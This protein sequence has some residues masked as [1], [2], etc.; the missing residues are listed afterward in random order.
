MLPLSLIVASAVMFITS[1]IMMVIGTRDSSVESNLELALHGIDVQYVSQIMSAVVNF[2][3][4]VLT[5]GRIWW[6]IRRTPKS[7]R[8]ESATQRT[9][10]SVI[11]IIV[12]SG[13]IYPLVII[14]DL[15]IVNTLSFLQPVDFAPTMVLAAG[16]APTLILVRVKMGKTAEPITTGKISN[17]EFASHGPGAADTDTTAY[18]SSQGN[19]ASSEKSGTTR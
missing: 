17:I 7:V 3:L 14:V 1:A 16:I 11:R 8:V 13:M 2:L 6:I 9:I 10:S 5:A 19:V 15:A 4:T 18:R 12:E